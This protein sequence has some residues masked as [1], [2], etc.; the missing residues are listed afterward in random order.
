MLLS[1]SVPSYPLYL[2]YNF[3]A[4]KP[5]ASNDREISSVQRALL[6]NG[7][8]NKHTFTATEERSFLRGPCQDISESQQPFSQ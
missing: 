4:C 7:S 2:L 6:S 8:T 1:V 3:V 5:V